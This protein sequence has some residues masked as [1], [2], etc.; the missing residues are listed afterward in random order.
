[1]ISQRSG[2]PEKSEAKESQAGNDLATLASL[3]SDLHPSL[4]SLPVSPVS[5]GMAVSSFL[6]S[7]A[8]GKMTQ[9][10]PQGT[11]G[12]HKL[13]PIPANEEG[14]RGDWQAGS[15]GF[16]LPEEGRRQPARPSSDP[17][18]L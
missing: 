6:F 1:M 15:C 8:S 12:I 16:G 10:Q 18:Q 3:P 4:L 7:L 14:K 13:V 5:W 11:K 2:S 9:A 17:T